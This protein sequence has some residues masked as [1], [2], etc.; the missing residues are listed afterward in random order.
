[1]GVCFLCF[2][3]L[4]TAMC[5]CS[6]SM[7]L[8]CV[9]TSAS[10]TRI[11]YAIMF[12]VSSLVSWVMLAGEIGERLNSQRRFTGEIAEC[13]S[14][15]N[16]QQCGA[17]WSQLAIFRIMFGAFLF[18]IFMGLVM[19]G[20]KSSRD[21]RAAWQNGFWFFKLLLWIG[22]TVAAFF[23]PNVWFTESWGYIALAGAFLYMIIQGVYVILFAHAWAMRFKSDDPGRAT[24]TVP[25]CTLFSIIFIITIN[26]VLYVYYTYGDSRGGCERNKVIISINLVLS[27]I[28]FMSGMKSN[29][30][31]TRGI[32]QPALI[33]SY[34]SYLT[35]SAVSQTTDRC[36]PNDNDPSDWLT[37]VVG[38]VLT[39]VVIVNASTM[40]IDPEAVK[41]DEA[42]SSKTTTTDENGDKV[43]VIQMYTPRD[44]EVNMVQ[45]VWWAFHV[46]IAL[47]CCF[48]QNVLTNW[49]SIRTSGG[50]PS[51]AETSVGDSIAPIWIQAV[52]GYVVVAIYLWDVLGPM[53]GPVC[54]PNRTWDRD[55]Q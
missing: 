21:V 33:S 4:G 2:A 23:I 20:V 16:A 3:V 14:G 49:S 5:C 8:C 35:W 45:Y 11:A 27:L 41:V 37:L 40:Y 18:F 1:M 43:T 46:Q 39:L 32:L 6:S 36:L 30:E 52:A 15:D 17:R 10:A 48:M 50:G 13:E 47:A 25:M 51:S 28:M 7:K 19:C 53:F 44:N 54:C 22:L 9:T 42:A 55:A 26:V 24:T 38:F 31:A 12:T 34:T 29:A